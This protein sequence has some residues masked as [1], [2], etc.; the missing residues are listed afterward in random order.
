MGKRKINSQNCSR[1][2]KRRRVN[3]IPVAEQQMAAHLA[4][5]EDDNDS[6]YQWVPCAAAP[7]VR[8]NCDDPVDGRGA[9]GAS[10]DEN[11]SNP[12][13]SP[14]SDSDGSEDDP[15][16]LSGSDYDSDATSDSSPD[17]SPDDSSSSSESEDDND[18]EEDPPYDN[19]PDED[20]PLYQDAP[21]SVGES[22]LS[23]LS[24]ALAHNLSGACVADILKLIEIHCPEPNRC[25]NSLYKYK[26]YFSALNSPLVRRY[27]CSF[28]ENILGGQDEVCGLCQRRRGVSFFIEMP[29]IPQ[30]KALFKRPGFYEL[31][32]D[33]MRDRRRRVDGNYEDIYDGMVYQQYQND[34]NIQPHNS[35]S[36]MWYTDGVRIFKSSKGQLWPF[37]LTVNELPYSHRT[38]IENTIIAGLWFGENKPNPISFLRFIREDL[39]QLRRG[40][41]VNLP[42]GNDLH[43]R[44]SV[45]SGTCDLPAKGLFLNMCQYNGLHGCQVCKFRTTRL[46]PAHIRNPKRIYPYPNRALQLRT[47]AEQLVFAR[48]AFQVR[49]PVMGVKGPSALAPIVQRPVETTAI[50]VMHQTFLGLTKFLVKVWFDPEWTDNPASIYALARVVDDRLRAACPPGF[51]ERHVRSISDHYKYWKAQELKLWLLVYSLPFTQDL[52]HPRFSNHH[53]LLV[54][55]ISILSMDSVS[56]QMVEIASEAFH[57]YV[58]QFSDLYGRDWMSPNLHLLLHLPKNV[59]KFGPLWT[60]TCF[61]YESLNGVLKKF[62]T[63]TRYADLQV[64]TAASMF[65]NLCAFRTEK[66]VPGRKPHAFCERLAHYQKRYALTNISDRFAVVGKQTETNNLPEQVVHALIGMDVENARFLQFY[67][68]FDK[69][70][71]ILFT[72]SCYVR[73]VTRNSSCTKFIHQGREMFG[74]VHSYLHVV[75]C[76]CDRQ[77]GNC[78]NTFYAVIR[79][80]SVAAAFRV[81]ALANAV[82]PL[83][84]QLVN[85]MDQYHAVEVHSLIS[86]CHLLNVGDLHRSYIIE[87]V[88]T[89][90]AE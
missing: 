71:N 59:E 6:D 65:L 44:A 20:P 17:E 40:V 10:S 24:L 14:E 55:G 36:L 78:I 42:D 34:V 76:D 61:P 52:H 35:L 84:H 72:S 39:I 74:I 11:D 63:G 79:Q 8:L 15:S 70:T 21:I 77:C 81:P 25:V 47:D 66:L 23:V 67:R 18:P 89:M 60:T 57:E 83:I 56:P 80:C 30:V 41:N 46:H 31:I 54:F 88:N 90:E 1:R 29:V 69:K 86:V 3:A 4:S 7:N 85:N 28:C 22:V 75:Q 64:Y 68:M 5:L 53:K 32:R 45:I 37:M 33:R 13:D 2:T 12:S 19:D 48:N 27:Y 62:V 43:I 82:L 9:A 58:R 51:V 87:P 50:D 49:R 38:R 73:G 16:S 26:K